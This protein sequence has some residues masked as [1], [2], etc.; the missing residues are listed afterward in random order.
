MIMSHVSC[1]SCISVEY[2]QS[3]SGQWLSGCQ[4]RSSFLLLNHLLELC[5]TLSLPTELLNVTLVQPKQLL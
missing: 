5:P 3:L 1:T 4:I 2:D